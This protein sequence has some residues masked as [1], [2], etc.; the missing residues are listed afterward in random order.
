MSNRQG[1]KANRRGRRRL[2]KRKVVVGTYD[3]RTDEQAS[4]L[5]ARPMLQ[6]MTADAIRAEL[7]ADG[8]ARRALPG[9]LGLWRQ[10]AALKMLAQARRKTMEET[11]VEIDQ[12]V[13]ALCGQPMPQQ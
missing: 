3:A 11:F 9:E 6:A 7:V 10:M 1:R 2:Q 8:V 13:V 5:F 4:L 12:E